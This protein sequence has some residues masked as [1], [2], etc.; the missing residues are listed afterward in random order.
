MTSRA[1]K[2]ALK[3]ERDLAAK[4]QRLA[5]TLAQSRVELDLTPATVE[6]VVRVALK[7]AHRKDLLPAPSP[8]GFEAPVYLLPE[9]PGTWAVARNTGLRHPVTGRE[10][11]VTFDQDGA[12]DRTDVVLLHLGHRLVEMCLRLLRAE[13]W[14]Q[15]RTQSGAAKLARVTARVVPGDLLRVPAVVAHGRVIV[16]GAEGT[17]LHEEIIAAGGLIEGGK[18]SRANKEEVTRWLTAAS[19]EPVPDGI[20]S[21]LT[22]LWPGLSEPL[23]RL[24]NGRAADRVRSMRATLEKRCGEEV[25]AIEAVL[26]ELTVAIQDALHSPV[27][28]QPSLFE[29]EE[30]NQLR[31]DREA[32]HSRLIAIPQQRER[33]VDAL[34]RRYADPTPR[35]FPAAV[36]FLVP[37]SIARGAH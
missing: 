14:A 34:R 33:E 15:A 32:L 23:A 18:L 9:L 35:W 8:P 5:D 27:A 28:V 16:T 13:L 22:E 12:A 1:S 2:A 6:Q 3:V 24:L 31:A 7:L 20:R 21:E 36:T 10:R 26:D 29:D 17:R 11:P 25:R 30:R 19:T 37:A 4:L